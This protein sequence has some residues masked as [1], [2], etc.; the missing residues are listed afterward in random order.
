[1]TPAAWPPLLDAMI[2]A[3]CLVDPK[4]LRITM[5]NGVMARLVGVPCAGFVGEPVVG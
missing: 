2:E 3:V 4:T 1:M 5:A